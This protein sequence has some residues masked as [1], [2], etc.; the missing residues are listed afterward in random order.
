[1]FPLGKSGQEILREIWRFEIS[2]FPRYLCRY[3]G[4]IFFHFKNFSGTATYHSDVEMR[5][6]TVE[7]FFYLLKISFQDFQNFFRSNV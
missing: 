3:P 7:C 1:M 4:K 6:C 2:R 5:A